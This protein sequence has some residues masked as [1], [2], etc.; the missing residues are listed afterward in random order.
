MLCADRVALRL[1]NLPTTVC[2]RLAYQSDLFPVTTTCSVDGAD[3]LPSTES[4]FT[5]VLAVDNHL[6]TCTVRH[7]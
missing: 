5:A 4:T 1:V 3:F 6:V 2:A 7:K